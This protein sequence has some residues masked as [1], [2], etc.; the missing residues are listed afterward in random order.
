MGQL[1]WT[2][3][4]VPSSLQFESIFEDSQGFIWL[5]NKASIHRFDG[6][7]WDSFL[8]DDSLEANVI[9]ITERRNG[10]LW[11]GLENGDIYVFKNETSQKFEPKEGTPKKAI[12]SL[13][14]D[15]DDRLWIISYGEGLYYYHHNT[16][17][18]I[19]VEDGLPSN[20]LY[21]GV[22]D[23]QGY[24]WCASD[25]GVA[26]IGIQNT[27]NLVQISTVTDQLPDQICTHL[28]ILGNKR[29]WVGMYNG[30]VA[31]IDISSNKLSQL[32]HPSQHQIEKIL[33]TNQASW[34]LDKAGILWKVN[35]TS[36]VKL[37][38]PLS[39]KD[40]FIDSFQRLWLI[41]KDNKIHSAPT[42]ISLLS[43]GPESI[44]SISSDGDNYIWV[45][46]PNGLYKYNI[47]SNSWELIS[48]TASLNISSLYYDLYGRLW[49]GT[50]GE[51]LWKFDSETNTLIQVLLKDNS[52][53]VPILSISGNKQD[54]WIAT[55]GG[56]FRCSFDNSGKIIHESHF[57]EADQLGINYIYQSKTDQE[58]KT[59]LATDGHGLGI[60]KNNNLHIDQT[61]NGSSLLSISTDPKKAIWMLNDEGNVLYRTHTSLDTLLPA[62]DQPALAIQALSTQRALIIYEH[63]LYL[64]NRKKKL[65]LPLLEKSQ[66][67]GFG[68][69]L[70]AIHLNKQKQLFLASEKGLVILETRGIPTEL[71]PRIRIK[72]IQ[73]NLGQRSLLQETYESDENHLNFEYAG[74]WYQ[75]P[76]AVSFRYRLIG[77]DLNW[78]YSK[79]PNAVYADLSPSRYTFEIQAGVRGLFQTDNI[80][81]YSFRIKKPFWQ[82]PL[83]IA[84]SIASLTILSIWIIRI[85]ES[86]IRLAEELRRQNAEHQFETLRSQI[87]PHFLFN[88]FSTLTDIVEENPKHAIK[89]INRLSDMFRDTLRY[90][91]DALI[92]LNEELT[93]LKNYYALQKER[94]GDTFHLHIQ[95][96]PRNL[97]KKLPPLVLQILVENALKHNIASKEKPLE[98]KIFTQK[99]Q[100][101]VQNPIQK[102][103]SKASSTQL[104]LQNIKE[105]FKLL[106][107]QNIHIEENQFFT[108]TLPLLD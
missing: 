45:G 78:I 83:F 82:H 57:Q 66:H 8:L 68:K 43:N 93:I 13:F 29:L 12:K 37:E 96:E 84:L 25:R 87:N 26:R 36:S 17:F 11:L 75:N 21:A 76:D 59:L 35:S 23:Y 41:D 27:K 105:R 48:S 28:E 24:V 16:L 51:G 108:V 47:S 80:K 34:I 103:G 74:L 33:P 32:Y 88:A 104:G 101:L 97:D 1:F 69:Q 40:I 61:L 30:A 39:I 86:R 6:L 49:I 77:R 5:G 31:E 14:F 58:G 42:Y 46:S 85:R 65:L 2:S 52:S 4:A 54:L 22:L 38:F 102:R 79:N 100:I 3:Y 60:W 15:K 63:A 64:L 71:S 19:D 107:G 95:I 94:Y 7:Q 55:F 92:P 18:N 9:S 91:K 81:S 67:T 44:Q 98:V 89:Y 70:N 53:K 106:S 50:L 90:R 62:F 73:I 10:E 56:A 72:D 20:D 99:N